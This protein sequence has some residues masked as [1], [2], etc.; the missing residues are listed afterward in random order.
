M[1]LSCDAGNPKFIMSE[2]SEVGKNLIRKEVMRLIVNLSSSV[3]VK[4]TEKGL[5]RSVVR[6]CVRPCLVTDGVEVNS[7]RAIG[8]LGF[9]SEA[10][11]SED[12]PGH[13]SLL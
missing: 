12:V 3:A 7:L 10:K 8:V 11:V 13:L 9:Q 2:D 1:F 4:G 5:L 6:A